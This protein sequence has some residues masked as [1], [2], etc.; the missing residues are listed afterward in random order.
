MKHPIVI[1]LLAG[2]A[3]VAVA[4][5]LPLLHMVRGGAAVDHGED[6]PWQVR[7]HGDASVVFGIELPGSTLADARRRWGDGLQIALMAERGSAGAVEGYVE[8]FDSGGVT[9]KLV[10]ATELPVATLERLRSDAAR[11]EAVDERTLRHHLR[12]ADLAGVLSA[13][14]VGITFIPAANLDADTLRERFGEPAERRGA[15]ERL[16]HWLYPQRGLAIVLDAQGKD[17]LQYVAPADFERRLRAPLARP[18]GP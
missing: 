1:A 8:G 6:L 17:L 18:A 10:L 9:G 11:V 15:G 2:L 3:V 16:E 12:A 14:I 13:P 7:R 4:L 5:A